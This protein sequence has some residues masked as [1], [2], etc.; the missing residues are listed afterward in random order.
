LIENEG[1]EGGERE[2]RTPNIATLI[3]TLAFSSDVRVWY[4]E[5]K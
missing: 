5:E 4:M 3:T 1:R 2:R